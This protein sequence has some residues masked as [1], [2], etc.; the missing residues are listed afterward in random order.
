MS[1]VVQMSVV[2]NVNAKKIGSGL[3]YCD[4]QGCERI[5]GLLQLTTTN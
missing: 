4:F 5:A 3:R 2:A 1:E